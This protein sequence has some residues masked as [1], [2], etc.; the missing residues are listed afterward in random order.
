MIPSER[1]EHILNFLNTKN[2][3][4]TTELAKKMYVSEPTIRRDL[5]ELEKQRLVIRT[6]GGATLAKETSF[7]NS[8]LMR[9]NKNIDK[10]NNLT[11]LAATFINDGY[12]I[13]LDSSSTVN[14]IIPYISCF[15]DITVITNGLKN[16]MDLSEYPRINTIIIGG[17]IFQN[18]TS[19]IGG[20][21]LNFVSDYNVDICLVSCR[22]ADKYGIYEANEPQALIK[23]KM[24]ANSKKRI[25]LIDS[26]KVNNKYFH[27][28]ANYSMF[29]YI[30][31]DDVEIFSQYNL[32]N[33]VHF[34][35]ASGGDN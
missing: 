8:Y 15:K 13:F 33:G 22:G 23:Q 27:F 19:V 9:E 31:T 24:L 6:H 25:L 20:K 12:T 4:S 14:T 35:E 1:I 2:F 21:A 10:K 5:I 7:E 17:T 11:E 16:A 34:V 26:S 30:I 29:D 32:G 28:L 18:S 3:A